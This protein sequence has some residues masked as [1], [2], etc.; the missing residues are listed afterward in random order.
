MEKEKIT[1]EEGYP[2]AWVCICNNTI[3]TV[4]FDTCTPEGQLCEPTNDGPWVSHY[5]CTECG[6]IIDQDTLEVIGRVDRDTVRK[7]VEINFSSI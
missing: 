5:L 3:S 2:E 6:R 4:G 7:S 1:Y